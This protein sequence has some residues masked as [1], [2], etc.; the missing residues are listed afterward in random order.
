M[1]ARPPREDAEKL[2]HEVDAENE[3]PTELSSEQKY[4]YIYPLAA[5][6]LER[7]QLR[8][9]DNGFASFAEA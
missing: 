8:L 7:M 9:R 4:E 1:I 5:E 6:K 2:Q 3:K